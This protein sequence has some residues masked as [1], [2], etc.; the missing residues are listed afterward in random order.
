M[1]AVQIK[2][3]GDHF[4]AVVNGAPKQNDGGGDCFYYSFLDGFLGLD[5]EKKPVLDP[6]LQAIIDTY[7]A[8]NKIE[9]IVS[10]RKALADYLLKIDVKNKLKHTF[11]ADSGDHDTCSYD[12]YVS[13]IR[14]RGFWAGVREINFLAELFKVQIDLS[15]EGRNGVLFTQEYNKQDECSGCCPMSA[16]PIDQQGSGTEVKVL[17]PSEQDR[18]LTKAVLISS[19]E[20]TTSFEATKQPANSV[21]AEPKIDAKLQSISSIL[22][23][24]DTANKDKFDRV[25]LTAKEEIS[26]V[27][28]DFQEYHGGDSCMVTKENMGSFEAQFNQ[29]YE[30]NAALR[31]V[32]EHKYATAFIDGSKQVGV[33][34]MMRS[35]L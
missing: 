34:P 1:A 32:G 35:R 28:S 6:N 7:K 10:L 15:V 18:Q 3:Y 9:A 2:H 5:V 23:D 4:T 8:G 24:L 26:S 25:L 22:T 27:T 31:N 20:A 21:G 12:A 19:F 13:N 17:S 14:K 33:V 11:A 29:I 30:A 16:G